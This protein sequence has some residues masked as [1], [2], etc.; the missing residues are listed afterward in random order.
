[1][2][3]AS[4][5]FESAVGLAVASAIVLGASGCNANAPSST[6]NN[7]SPLRPLTAAEDWPTYGHD[8][9]RTNCNSGERTISA[10]TVRR[11]A[12][13]WTFDVGTNGSVTASG[14][15]VANDRV[16]VGSSVAEGDNY[17]ALDAITGATLWSADVGHGSE[18][19]E[20][21]C[22]SVG[23]GSTAAVAS[24]LLV[25]G[26]G[27]TAYYGLDASTGRVLWR[28]GL[29]T[30]PAGFAWSSPLLAG[31][32]AYV[33]VASACVEGVRG[34]LRVL[35]AA[36]G[37]LLA[38]QFFVP[39]GTLGASVWNSATLTPD[40]RAV[41]VATGNDTGTEGRYEQAVV[42]LDPQTLAILA[43]DKRGPIGQNQDF[44]TT[45]I[46]FSDGSGRVLVGASHKTGE[47]YAYV[48]SDIRAGPV[49]SRTVGAIIGLA[50][51]FDP[52]VGQGG[53]LF[54]GGHDQVGSGQIHA[55][56]PATGAD[57]WPPMT[58]GQAHGNLAL[59]NGVL[60]ANTGVAGL[61]TFDA[62]TGASLRTLE[63]AEPGEAY[64]GPVVA[65][66]TVYWLSGPVLN[67]WRP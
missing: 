30:E 2:G 28:H 32:R 19:A 4:R 11:L 33:G 41:I 48:A 17:F 61:R 20:I 51:A 63:P 24:N 55:V 54:F 1:M 3:T 35:E 16:Y 67:A 6:E 65:R 5:T 62:T 9:S 31:G 58:V 44:V 39:P 10:A 49:W 25:V 22:G 23:L 27:D 18:G 43:A 42:S 14:P 26:G 45:P 52:D 38:N 46:V 15:L 60:Y 13:S 56:D 8:V 57:R 66:G 21:P 34:E 37:A 53:T 29:G 12:P 64:S 36:T 7:A 47:F 40:G 59:A 50:P